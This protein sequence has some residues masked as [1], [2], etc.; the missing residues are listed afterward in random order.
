MTETPKERATR[1]VEM[2]VERGFGA[3]AERI[4]ENE[5][6]RRG[7]SSPAVVIAATSA[8]AEVLREKQARDLS[9][10]ND[11]GASRSGHMGALSRATVVDGAALRA[12]LSSEAAPASHWDFCVWWDA[13]PAELKALVGGDNG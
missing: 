7:T 9:Y 6:R 8:D 12:W 5:L 2:M 4:L 10:L 13:M 11:T 1:L 3:D